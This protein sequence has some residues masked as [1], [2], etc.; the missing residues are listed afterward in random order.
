MTNAVFVI[1]VSYLLGCFNTGFYI[2]NLVTGRDIR[3]TA[4]GNTGSRN[5]GR[6]LGTKGFVITLIGDAGKG[7]VA[8]WLAQQASYADWLGFAALLSVVSGHIW[9]MQLSFRGG[10]GFATFAGGLLLIYPLLLLSGLLASALF[11]LV[12]RRTTKSGLAALALS[13]SFMIADSVH[14]GLPWLSVTFILYLIIVLVV[15]FG[16]RD[17]IRRDFLGYSHSSAGSE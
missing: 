13:P 7:A 1:I 12:F 14:K 15:L 11:L 8:V 10:K 16:H 2:V 4:S 9:P 3:S 17:N 6:L 5:V